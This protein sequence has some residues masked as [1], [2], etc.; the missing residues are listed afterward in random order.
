MQETSIA[1]DETA[2]ESAAQAAEAAADSTGQSEGGSTGGPALGSRGRS[3]LGRGRTAVTLVVVLLVLAAVVASWQWRQATDQANDLESTREQVLKAAERNAV[4]ISSYD[5]RDFDAYTKAVR[6][7]AT[8]E[9]ADRFAGREKDL[10]TVVEQ[11]EAQ[12]EATVVDAALQSASDNE[13]VVL[14]F[15]DQ[16]LGGAKTNDEPPS[17]MRMKMTLVRT[18]DRWLVSKLELL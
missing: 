15:V 18:G 13:A 10:R 7:L 16:T 3:R 8:G 4:V 11:S 9:F 1:T 17:Q 5:H 2:G 12:V 14:L 6:S